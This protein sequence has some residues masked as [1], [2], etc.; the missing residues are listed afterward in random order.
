[1]RLALVLGSFVALPLALAAVASA[2]P[3]VTTVRYTVRRDG[4]PIGT[5]TFRLTREGAE[6]IAE[7]S[8][9]VQVK[10]AF[11]TVYRFDQRETERWQGDRLVA[12]NA[13]TD[14]NGAVHR[15]TAQASGNTL[16]VDADGKVSNVDGGVIPASLWNAELVGRTIA[17]NLQ[18]G[19]PIPVSVIDHGREQLVLRGRA[20]T[21]HHYSISTSFAQDVWYD[22]HRKLVKVEMRGSDGSTIRYQP[23]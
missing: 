7:V 21:A 16:V 9:H 3:E 19:N 20:T 2:E 1:M 14:D 10:L 5:S 22:Q 11:I 4:A 23:G 13:Q 6:T 17:L 12:L 15:V 18:T 8:T